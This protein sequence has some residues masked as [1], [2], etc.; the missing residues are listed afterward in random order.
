[1]LWRQRTT[2]TE[3]KPPL[4]KTT[5]GFSFLSSFCFKVAFYDAEWIG[6]SFSDQ[7]SGAAFRMKFRN[8]ECRDLRSACAPYRRRNRYKRFYN[9]LPLILESGQYSGNMA[10][11]GTS[12]CQNNMLHENSSL[13][14]DNIIWLLLSTQEEKSQERLQHGKCR[15]TEEDEKDRKRRTA[16]KKKLEQTIEEKWLRIRKRWKGNRQLLKAEEGNTATEQEPEA[17]PAFQRKN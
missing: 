5:F 11:N 13:E 12:A 16:E 1:M 8:T 7:S 2:G 17:A 3:T 15:G 4:E 9:L 10:G 6:K 14:F